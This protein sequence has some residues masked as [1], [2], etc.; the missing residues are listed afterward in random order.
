MGNAQMKTIA[1]TTT[2][3][4]WK[5]WSVNITDTATVYDLKKKI[6]DDCRLS[7]ARQEL[8]NVT[9]LNST[10]HVIHSTLTDQDT[11][12]Y[13]DAVHIRYDMSLPASAWAWEQPKATLR[14]RYDGPLLER[15]GEKDV[16]QEDGSE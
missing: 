8:L 5:R 1:V 3:G 6:T 2:W 16:S 11:V 14:K 13:V 7:L 10:H 4:D 12:S 9:L 15:W